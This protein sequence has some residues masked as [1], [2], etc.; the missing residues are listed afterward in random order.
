[1]VGA[2]S[3]YTVKRR[4]VEIVRGYCYRFVQCSF[5][6]GIVMLIFSILFIIIGACQLIYIIHFNGCNTLTISNNDSDND[7]DLP[8]LPSSVSS[9]S[10]SFKCNRQAM[11]VLGITFLVTGSVLFLISLLV[12]KYSRS[13]EENNVIR[14]TASSLLA[15]NAKNT[16][17]HHHPHQLCQ[18]HH[19]SSHYHRKP[20]SS[21]N[22]QTT[23]IIVS[24]R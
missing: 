20:S 8:I 17:N 24:I 16:H 14:A 12:T 5:P 19:P 9:M 3:P 22:D 23:N 21:S 10:S 1:M 6:C 11:K 4:R 18:Q 15:N 2:F 13:S 7:D